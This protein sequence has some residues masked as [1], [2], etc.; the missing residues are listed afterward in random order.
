M[1]K[2]NA[3]LGVIG[4]WVASHPELAPE[5]IEF[6]VAAILK[7]LKKQKQDV[8]VATMDAA[9][10]QICS[11]IEAMSEE[12]SEAEQP[13]PE[14]DAELDGF[15]AQINSWSSDTMRE[16]MKDP[17]VADAVERVLAA[18]AKQKP[19]PQPKPKSAP[20]FKPPVRTA[21]EIAVEKMSSADMKRAIA[22]GQGPAI[23]RILSR[24]QS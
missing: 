21:E 15:V 8:T 1:S 18:K 9:F 2:L 10:D 22:K 6:T 11:A 4:A 7:F 13:R 17:E 5:K 23:E 24:K 19:K 20:K 16:N 12:E 3:A 14:Q